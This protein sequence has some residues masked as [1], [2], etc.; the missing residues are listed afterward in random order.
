MKRGFS[1]Q[2]K[3][4][5]YRAA[6]ERAAHRPRGYRLLRRGK[7][8]DGALGLGGTRTT[9]PRKIGIITLGKNIMNEKI[10]VETTIYSAAGL[11][12]VAK[13]ETGDQPMPTHITT[14][15][16]N[17]G[18]GPRNAGGVLIG[19]VEDVNGN[20]AREVPEFVPTRAELL[21][22]VKHW[23]FTFLKREYFIF[24]T[25][26]VGSDDNR[27][28]PFA[29]R[30]VM[31]IIELLGQDAIQAVQEE[32]DA[33]AKSIGPRKWKKFCIYL[34]P[35]FLHERLI[36]FGKMLEEMAGAGQASDAE[37]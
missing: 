32:R 3:V 24:S 7:I 25:S 11:L 2:R 10:N 33:F 31:R 21:E 23:E 12:R 8:T 27:L 18:L 35:D 28:C 20:G 36:A 30:R 6:N 19:C 13:K 16:D 26:T 15:R 5:F 22:L 37:Q 17:A 9:A 1:S 4:D 29:V 34:G 14:N